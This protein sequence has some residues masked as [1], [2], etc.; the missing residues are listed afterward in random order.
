MPRSERNASLF[1]SQARPELQARA[2]EDESPRACGPCRP[3]LSVGIS[4]GLARGRACLRGG[5]ET[6]PPRGRAPDPGDSLAARGGRT[7]AAVCSSTSR[8]RTGRRG[9][10]Q[11]LPAFTRPAPGSGRGA[12]RVP[13][14][15]RAKRKEPGWRASRTSEPDT[16]CGG[17]KPRPPPE[18]RRPGA[19]RALQG[20]PI[21]GVWSFL[22]WARGAPRMTTGCGMENGIGEV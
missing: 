9:A 20:S 16:G 7:S 2:W 19:L 11:P 14:T 12:A 21:P 1:V 13:E 3:S 10:R 5:I 6:G 15:L 8:A 17:E 18:P 22:L 4:G